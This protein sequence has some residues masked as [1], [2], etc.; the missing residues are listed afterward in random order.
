M[1]NEQR[2]RDQM[3]DTLRERERVCHSPFRSPL[4]VTGFSQDQWPGLKPLLAPSSGVGLPWPLI[5]LY[6]RQRK[7]KRV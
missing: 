7:A 2:D 1:R 6:L 4:R 3:K 5:L